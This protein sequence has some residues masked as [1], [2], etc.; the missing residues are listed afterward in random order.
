V[1][2]GA[3]FALFSVI[4]TE[5]LEMI[6]SHDQLA[7]EYERYQQMKDNDDALKAFEDGYEVREWIREA[8][9][10]GW[11]NGSQM[12]AYK[13]WQSYLGTLGETSSLSEASEYVFLDQDEWA[14]MK[15]KVAVNQAVEKTI[16]GWKTSVAAHLTETKSICGD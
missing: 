11:M 5:E 16:C 13:V 15:F 6:E 12:L 7:W 10:F 14:L 3:G 1:Y 8:C 2:S 4:G 9:K